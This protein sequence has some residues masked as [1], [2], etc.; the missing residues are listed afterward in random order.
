MGDLKICRHTLWQ[1]ISSIP[2]AH[3]MSIPP[4]RLRRHSVLNTPLTPFGLF[5]GPAQY[6]HAPR[7]PP[8]PLRPSGLSRQYSHAAPQLLGVYRR[9]RPPGGHLTVLKAFGHC[10]AMRPCKGRMSVLLW[11]FH[12]H[13]WP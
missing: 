7:L 13:K 4:C 9:I 10:R 11:V 5:M 3:G 2:R 6:S 1:G 8:P 12:A